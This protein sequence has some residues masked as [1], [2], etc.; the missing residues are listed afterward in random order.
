[1]YIAWGIPAVIL[2][3]LVLA[4]LTDRP[5]QARWL[6]ADE[7]DALLAELERE[8]AEG[9]A[10]H[11]HSLLDG[12]R[13][14]RVLLLRLVYFLVVT[15]SYGVEFFMPS[16]LRDWYAL[17]FDALTW[18]V[19]LPPLL[20]VASQLFVGW[21]SDRYKERWFHTAV[22]MAVGALGLVLVILSRGNL[23]L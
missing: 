18:L 4:A 23:P 22:P 8:K 11:K 21:S 20:A 10:R 19:I 13:H 5:Q 16:I 7:R 15:G 2:G 3:F 12:L 17:Q 14:P 1:I 9:A 6:A